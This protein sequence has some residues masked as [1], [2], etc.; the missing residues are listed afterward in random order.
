MTGAEDTVMALMDARK[1]QRNY[2]ACDQFSYS[3]GSL[4][5]EAAKGL[6]PPACHQESNVI[7]YMSIHVMSY[8]AI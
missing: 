5:L 8:H 3:R 1:L 7:S 2:Q 6:R 4:P